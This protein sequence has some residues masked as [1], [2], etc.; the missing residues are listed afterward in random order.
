MAASITI[1]LFSAPAC[2]HC[3]NARKRLQTMVSEL[4]DERIRY[5]EVDV[6]EAL[7][8]AVSLGILMTPAIAIDGKLIF[9]ALPSAKRLRRELQKRIAV[10]SP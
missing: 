1:E 5:Q 4:G 10:L 2:R 9:S 8:Y 7:D 3:E 6:L